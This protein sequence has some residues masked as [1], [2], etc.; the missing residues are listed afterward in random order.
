LSERFI[1][2]IENGKICEAHNIVDF[3]SPFIQT[4]LIDQIVLEKF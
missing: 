4:G 1:G 2:K 3:L